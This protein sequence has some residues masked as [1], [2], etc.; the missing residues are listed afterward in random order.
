MI[1]K[2]NDTTITIMQSEQYISSL[3]IIVKELIEN[4][5]DANAR[6]IKIYLD[7]NEIKVEDDGDGIQDISL[8]GKLGYTSKQSVSQFVIDNSKAYDVF[9]YGFRGQALYALSNIAEIETT[10]CVKGKR[11]EKKCHKSDKVSLCTREKGTTVRIKN[12]FYNSNIR[13]KNYIQSLKKAKKKICEMLEAY[14][15]VNCANFYVYSK[16]KLMYK[17]TGSGLITT[18]LKKK[19][20]YIIDIDYFICKT[21]LFTLYLGTNISKTRE[22]QYIFID[23]RPVN[24]KSIK[25]TIENTF[26]LYFF[27]NPYFVLILNY[28]SDFNVSVDKTYS[29]L[30]NEKEVCQS[31]KLEI[32]KKFENETKINFTNQKDGKM[33]HLCDKNF[34]TQNKIKPNVTDDNLFVP[35]D[36][37]TSI[38]NEKNMQTNKYENKENTDY[39]KLLKEYV[40]E[41][42][43]SNIDIFDACENTK[44]AD[45]FQNKRYK[46]KQPKD[47]SENDENHCYLKNNESK[48]YDATKYN[49]YTAEY[50]VDTVKNHSKLATIE[51]KLCPS[52][53]LVILKNNLHEGFTLQKN[54]F[55]D[56]KIIGQFNNGFILTK[57]VKNCIETMCIIDQHAADEINNFETIQSCYNVIKQKLIVPIPLQ[58]NSIDKLNIETNAKALRM[59][60]YDFDE[61]FNLISIPFYKNIVFDKNDFYDVLYEINGNN[62]LDKYVFSKKIKD[63]MASKACR[64]SIMIGAVLTNTQMEKIVQNLAK[65]KYPWKC[66]HGRPVVKILH[67]Q[68]GKY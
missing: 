31:L 16:K 63:K 11:A 6:N 51:P 8:V 55:L 52:Q 33:E 29:L 59:N 13:Y 48:N 24:I 25:K 18:E 5:L 20:S 65:L 12:V 58:P 9:S 30:Q 44:L 19:Y 64:T 54:D 60:G 43:S 32:T 56:M 1:K 66:P 17:I 3:N 22:C 21:D 47:Y 57:M 14:C 68:M 35:S 39:V 28:Y 42:N 37:D 27:G 53:G 34:A 2:L 10:T 36:L 67:T 23:K 4:S 38:Q 26:N 62:C 45:G 49:A 15:F 41:Y 61:Y 46:Y 50:G 7:D 40:D